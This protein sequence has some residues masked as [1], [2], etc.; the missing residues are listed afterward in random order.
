MTIF[1]LGPVFVAV[2]DGTFDLVIVKFDNGRVERVFDGA[3]LTE[4]D[5][6]AFFK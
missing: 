3:A 5:Y 4:D 6:R 2:L 1:N